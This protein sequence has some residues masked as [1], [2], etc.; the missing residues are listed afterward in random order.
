MSAKEIIRFTIDIEVDSDKALDLRG[1][2][3]PPMRPVDGLKV[4]CIETL[5]KMCWIAEDMNED[6]ESRIMWSF[7][8]RLDP[9]T[10]Q[11]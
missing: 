2:D 10:S 6:I 3:D 4:R 5:E 1:W 11:F 9:S 7:H 8:E